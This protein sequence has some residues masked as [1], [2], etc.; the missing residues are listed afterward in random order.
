M[1]IC[2][3]GGFFFVAFCVFIYCYECLCHIVLGCDCIFFFLFSCVCSSDVMNVMKIL[4]N[5]PVVFCQFA[6]C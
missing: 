1:C 5:L 4:Q 6:L 2:G 3:G